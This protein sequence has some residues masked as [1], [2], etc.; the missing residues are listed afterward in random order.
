MDKRTSVMMA[1]VT[2]PAFG[3][4]FKSNHRAVSH[5]CIADDGDDRTADM[6]GESAGNP[7][8]VCVTADGII[9]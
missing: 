6:G 9:L 2:D 8:I 4:A 3:M 1:V 7:F 5:Y